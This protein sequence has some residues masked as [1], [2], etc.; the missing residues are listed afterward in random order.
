MANTQT[1]PMDV[2]G[3]AAEAATKKNAEELLKR[4][5][6][7]S[8]ASQVEAEA[9]KTNVFDPQHPETPLVLDE[10]INVG[11][12]TNKDTVIIRTMHDIED[13]TYGVGQTFTFKAGKS[14][15]VTRHMAGYLEGLGYIWR[16]NE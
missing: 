5:D 13:M 8:I 14:Y 1:S 9:D 10:I 6:E 7:I 3:R 4:K 2:T 15:R 16:P 11:I 12:D